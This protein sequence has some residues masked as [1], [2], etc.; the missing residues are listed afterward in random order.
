MRIAES[1]VLNQIR[2][3]IRTA[4]GT[5]NDRIA[6]DLFLDMTEFMRE[7]VACAEF[8][9]CLLIRFAFETPRESRSR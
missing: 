1:Q 7:E 8:G 9:E 4:I 3:H 6:F 5:R 2:N